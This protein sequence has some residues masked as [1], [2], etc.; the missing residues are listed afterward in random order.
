VG[1][2]LTPRQG[3][4]HFRVHGFEALDGVCDLAVAGEGAFVWAVSD[5][6]MDGDRV[7]TMLLG[8]VCRAP[9]EWTLVR[10]VLEGSAFVRDGR[11]YTS[12]RA[13]TPGARTASARRDR[14]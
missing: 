14:R 7:F 10:R 3:A 6:A 9:G 5:E 13:R 4:S 8:A 1:A 11:W 12:R 2:K